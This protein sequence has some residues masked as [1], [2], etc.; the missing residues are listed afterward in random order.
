VKNGRNLFNRHQVDLLVTSSRAPR[1]V[2]LRAGGVRTGTTGLSLASDGILVRHRL[3]HERPLSGG[4]IWPPT[5]RKWPV[6]ARS[7]I[8]GYFP[9]DRPGITSSEPSERESAQTLRQRPPR[10]P[11]RILVSSPAKPPPFLGAP[12]RARH[13]RPPD[14]GRLT[15][16]DQ[17]AGGRDSPLRSS[18]A[19]Q[20]AIREH[21]RCIEHSTVLVVEVSE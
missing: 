6:G 13:A 15:A 3:G 8:P 1:R 7:P 21:G 19:K 9:P 11:L 16:V 2:P 5:D 17:K 10:L 20:L 14:P 18:S 4:L 12:R